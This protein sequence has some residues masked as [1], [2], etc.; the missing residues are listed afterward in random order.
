MAVDEL[1]L[2]LQAVEHGADLWAAPMNHDRIDPDLLHQHDI[3]GE[4]CRQRGIAHRMAA[5]FD[6]KGGPAV[7]PHEWQR[8]RQLLGLGQ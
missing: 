8:L 6:D 7:A 5:I 3:A 2:D 1:A 4:T